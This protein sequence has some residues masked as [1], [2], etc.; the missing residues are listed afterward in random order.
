[1][2]P[3]IVS[4]SLCI[5]LFG[6]STSTEEHSDLKSALTFHASFDEGPDADFAKGD[7]T[8][9]TATAVQP[10]LTTREGLPEEA[11]LVEGG[12]FGKGIHFNTPDE[13]KGT[14]TFYKL[15]DNFTYEASNWQGSVSFWL[16]LTPD[17]DLR[18]GFTDPIQLTSKSALDGA[19]W[20]DFMDKNPRHFRMGVYPDKAIWNP[21]N[22]RMPDIPEEQKPWITYE[23][24][25]FSRD[26]WTHI[27]M[28]IEGFNNDD[29]NAV[30]K[31]YIDGKLH[32][33]LSGFQQTYTWDLA[34]AQI[35][36]G[37]N[38]RGSMDE[39]SCFNRAL[40]AKEVATLYQL[41]EGIAGIL[42]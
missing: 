11:T 25:P 31:L 5:A 37:V 2:K 24:P 18:P 22:K 23:Y 20:V 17:E 40:T 14:R 38:F 34:L 21:E 41:P 10:E 1:M 27:V 29:T 6:C 28:T 39:L 35:R 19:I 42:K 8:L 13:V 30:G 3:Y 26:H 12:R 32:G 9:Y 36:L 4:I 15:P 16:K 7:G 33:E